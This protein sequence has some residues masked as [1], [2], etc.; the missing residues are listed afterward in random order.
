V[1]DGSPRGSARFATTRWSVVVAAGAAAPE[2]RAALESLC[3]DYWYPLYAYARRRGNSPED[4][5][6]L[7]QGFFLVLLRRGS[8]ADVDPSRGR[9]RT[10]LLTAFQRHASHERARDNALKRGGGVDRLPFEIDDGESRYSREPVDERTPESLYERRWA[11][12]LLARSVDRLRAENAG[13][14]LRADAL[15]PHVGGPG[16]ARPYAELASSLGISEGAVKAAV[17]RMR[18]RC[19]EI[20]RDEVAHTVADAGEVEDELRRL[21]AALA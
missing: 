4:S 5:Q 15:L 21:V 11:M 13:D 3:R 8:L 12:T 19:R 18:V 9:F 1:T 16:E 20:L 7:V 6:D 14:G 10:F 17:H 2:S